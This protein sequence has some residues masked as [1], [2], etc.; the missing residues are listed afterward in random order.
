MG[1]DDS[2]CGIG[3]L[4]VTSNKL[5]TLPRQNSICPSGSCCSVW[6]MFTYLFTLVYVFV[7]QTTLSQSSYSKEML[8]KARGHFLTTYIGPL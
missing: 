6:E 1:I 3:L 5:V 7:Y 4:G 8:G 2:G